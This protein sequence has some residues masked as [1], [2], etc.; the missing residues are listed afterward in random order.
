VLSIEVLSRKNA[1]RSLVASRPLK[2]GHVLEP[3]DLAVKRPAFGLPPAALEW[4]VGHKLRRD[5]GED[6]FLTLEHLIE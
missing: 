5:L 6:D 1:R 3:K 4:V 2:A